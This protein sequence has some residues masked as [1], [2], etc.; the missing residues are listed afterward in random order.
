ME[1]SAITS[2]T[3]GSSITGNASLAEN[4]DTFLSLLT[5]QLQYQDPRSPMD[6]TE[7]TNQLT[8]FSQVEQAIKTNSQLETLIALNQANQAVGALGYLGRTVEV[9][10]STVNLED[11]EATILYALPPGAAT[12]VV[13]I[14]DADGSLVRM[15]NGETGPGR[16]EYVWDGNNEQGTQVPDGVYRIAVTALDANGDVLDGTLTGTIGRVTQVNTEDQ[17]ILLMLGEVAV[18]VDQI[19]AIRE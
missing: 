1:T 7:F 10:S 12:T 6:T 3:A 19:V 15:I 8:Q 9:A 11:G 4:F 2:S 5:T 14:L 18:G 16:H 13:S 17:P